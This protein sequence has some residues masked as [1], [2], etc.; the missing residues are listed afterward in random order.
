MDNSEVKDE[1]KLAAS[2]IAEQMFRYVLKIASL[3]ENLI[4]KQKSRFLNHVLEYKEAIDLAKFSQTESLS[5]QIEGN[6]DQHQQSQDQNLIDFDRKPMDQA[7]DQEILEAEQARRL[8]YQALDGEMVASSLGQDGGVA[9]S[10]EHDLMSAANA[11]NSAHGGSAAQ[12]MSSEAFREYNESMAHS[13]KQDFNRS[14]YS[15]ADGDSLKREYEDFFA[16][17][18]H[19]IQQPHN[20]TTI[21]EDNPK[22]AGSSEK[23]TAET[24]SATIK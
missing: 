6:F 24:T 21:Q 10:R 14:R 4:V 22:D 18:V 23:T 1:E 13:Q 8:G 7:S 16:E 3:D 15:K 9:H 19:Q 11:I 20:P 12:S 5:T 2:D 17:P